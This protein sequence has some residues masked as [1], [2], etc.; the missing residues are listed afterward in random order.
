[1]Q[2]SYFQSTPLRRYMPWAVVAVL[3]MHALVLL[4]LMTLNVPQIQHKTKKPVHVRIVQVQAAIPNKSQPKIE[5]K[6]K[7][8]PKP[9]PPKP[10]PKII[11]AQP[12]A[13]PAPVVPQPT[14]K[15]VA[16]QPKV[17]AATT[18]T[19]HPAPVAK[20]TV[21]PKPE[22][23]AV[24]QG[25]KN[26]VIGGNGVQWARAPKPN[27]SNRDLDGQSR[28]LIVMIDADEKGNI[29]MAK[30]SQSS[31]LTNLDDKILRSVRNA[32]FKPYKENG[33]AIAIRAEQPFELTLNPND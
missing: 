28:K 21:E 33:V 10:Q 7:V 25:P 27:Y 1:M 15:P 22:V 11:T 13:K 16:V 23:A 6:P 30:L 31:G 12:Q 32:K 5:P 20:V 24:T 29:T 2:I 8:E 18:E 4:L 9:Q 19:T 17:T 26:V 3:L 14:T